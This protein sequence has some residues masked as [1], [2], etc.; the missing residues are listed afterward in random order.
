[1]HLATILQRR[2][3]EVQEV[4]RE[5]VELWAEGRNS[6]LAR[7]SWR[8]K[9]RVAAM[10]R[11]AIIK[12]TCFGASLLGRLSSGTVTA[13]TQRAQQPPQMHS[14]QRMNAQDEG[15]HTYIDENS[16]QTNSM[17]QWKPQD[18]QQ[19]QHHHPS[20]NARTY[21]AKPRPHPVPK[22]SDAR[23]SN[24]TLAGR[25]ECVFTCQGWS[26]INVPQFEM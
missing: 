11:P 4:D 13:D 17:Q 1:M 21:R 16:N 25:R 6:S 15:T 18:L 26:D 5:P 24:T 7:G 10:I 23:S 14:Q 8:V 20:P 2:G 9:P 19:H 3:P 22:R 12:C